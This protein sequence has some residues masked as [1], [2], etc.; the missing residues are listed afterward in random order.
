MSPATAALLFGVGGV[1][2]VLN[3]VAGGG[4]LLTFPALVA[5]GLPP[6]VANATS[7]VSQWPG[8]VAASWAGRQTLRQQPQRA[9]LMSASALGGLAGGLLVTVVSNAVFAGL[10]PWLIL[11]A[12]VLFWAGPQLPRL[13]GTKQTARPWPAPCVWT[14]QFV[15]AVYGGFFGG[16]MGIM[17]LALFALALPGPLASLN[18]PKNLMSVLIAGVAVIAFIVAGLVHWPSGLVMLAGAVSGGVYGA[19]LA[20]RL[21]Q[22]LLRAVVVALGLVLSAVFFWRTLH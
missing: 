11:L 8:Y 9:G 6:T 14:A 16:G 15:A 3:A 1:A 22:R 13:T 10:V 4:T 21:P 19:R 7:A 5:A 17:M 18:A 2:G 20:Q 12:T